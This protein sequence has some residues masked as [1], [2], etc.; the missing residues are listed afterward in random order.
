MTEDLQTETIAFL[1]DP[2][3]H[4]A[5]TVERADTHISLVFLAGD[6]VYKL[7]RAV[8]FSYLDY[9]TEP[10][11]RAA[12]EREFELNRRFAPGLYLA[13]KPVVRRED[14]SLALGGHGRPVD[15]VVEMRRFDQADLFDRMAQE[16][17]LTPGLVTDLAERIA[18]AHRTAPH[19]PDMGG[20]V[21]IA[22]AIHMTRINLKP[23]DAFNRHTIDR[24]HAAAMSSLAT[25]GDLL[26]QRRKTGKVRECHGDLHLRNICLF[27]GR[28]TLFD[29]I[30]FSRSIACIDILF[31]LA[32]LL[33]DLHHRGLGGLGNLVFNHYLDHVN[34]TDG[35]P[36]LPLFLSL[37]ASI[38]AQVTETA[39]RPL[40][41]GTA[42]DRGMAE[43]LAY[44]DLATALLHP[45]E[46]CLI[47]I[48]GFSGSGKTT[49]ARGLAGMLRPV[50]GA[51]VLRSDVIRKQLQSV[52]EQVRLPDSAYGPAA[53]GAVYDTIC[54]RA[55]AVLASGCS[56]I[57]DAVF[58]RPEDRQAIAKVARRVGVAFHGVW[59][60]AS[61][62][63]LTA[64]V[65]AR[66]ADASDATAS[67][68][69]SQLAQGP[70]P[71]DWSIVD[72][73]TSAERSIALAARTAGL[74]SGLVFA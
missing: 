17:R 74:R 46:P 56:V 27:E 8:R 19:A 62:P 7:K 42:R 72:A 23:G 70:G 2:S 36:L 34:E 73:E 4:R 13:V 66:L 39:A 44:L 5:R 15:W 9:S 20:E 51:R 54:E 31:D 25:H 65:A 59:L 68:V 61:Q 22:E 33:M 32:F 37:R 18:E 48:G 67:V 52:A 41:P 43:A 53:S 24:W 21:G 69:R 49:V 40:E 50:P 58:A 57:A 55:A 63:T 60:T 11:R 71:L 16:D 3:T 14:G 28:P 64:R 45:D 38:R 47:A 10:L 30:E 6:R 29:G 1:A 35:L 12:C 26:E